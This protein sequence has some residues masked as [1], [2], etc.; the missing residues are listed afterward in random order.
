MYRSEITVCMRYA[1]GAVPSDL[2]R[3]FNRFRGR[4]EL[5]EPWKLPGYLYHKL[6]KETWRTNYI[7]GFYTG[8]DLPVGRTLITTPIEPF[9]RDPTRYDPRPGKWSKVEN[10]RSFSRQGYESDIY[11]LLDTTVEPTSYDEYDVLFGDG[12]NFVTYAEQVPD[13]TV[14]ICYRGGMH[15]SQ[16]VAA[17]ERRLDELEARK[18]VRIEASRPAILAENE[19]TELADVLL[20]MGDDRTAETFRTAGVDIPIHTIHTTHP[21]GYEFDPERRDYEDARR[22]FLWFGGTGPVLKGLDRVLDVFAELEEVTLYVCGPVERAEAFTDLYNEELYHTD[23]IETVGWVDVR[24]RTFK[25]IIEQCAYHIYPSGSEGSSGAVANCMW[26]S[27]VPIVTEAVF[28][29]TDDWG[30]SLADDDLETI[31]ETVMTAANRDPDSVR[32]MAHRAATT[33][34]EIYARERYSREID[35]I[36]RTILTDADR[37][38][39]E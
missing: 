17:Y 21:P 24:S 30:L 39:T 5:V 10:A 1:F 22:N 23:N 20:V 31:R 25:R 34:R 15:W 9:Y 33:A 32:S 35:D 3:R 18:G 8:T 27:L 16:R 13:D 36:F 29:E 4:R 14:R 7:H 26:R 37:P 38:I 19:A 12:K 6:A 11:H 2:E 28:G